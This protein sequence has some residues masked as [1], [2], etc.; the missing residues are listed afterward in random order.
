MVDSKASFSSSS[1]PPGAEVAA[2]GAGFDEVGGSG[3][4]LS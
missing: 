4:R 1:P 2:F 3:S